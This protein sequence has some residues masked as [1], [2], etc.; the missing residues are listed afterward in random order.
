MKKKYLIRLTSALFTQVLSSCY[1]QK[2]D[3]TPATP[4]TPSENTV[5]EEKKTDE[6]LKHYTITWKHYDGRV[7]AKTSISEGKLPIYPKQNPRRAE[8][9]TSKYEF[10]GW[11][12]EIAVAKSDATYTAKFNEIKKEVVMGDGFIASDGSTKYSFAELIE[13]GNQYINIDETDNE[14]VIN[15][16]KLDAFSKYGK[17]II[18]E[19]YKE[20]NITELYM[21]A[22]Y[23]LN[24]SE[25]VE[26]LYLPSTLKK[27]GLQSVSQTNITSLTLPASLQNCGPRAFYKSSKLKTVKILCQNCNFFIEEEQGDGMNHTFYECGAL[28]EVNFP[29]AMN[30]IYPMFY[31]CSALKKVYLPEV[32]KNIQ[33]EAFFASSSLSNIDFPEGLENIEEWAFHGCGLTSVT[34]PKSLKYCSNAFD[35]CTKLKYAIIKAG[36]EKLKISNSAFSGCPIE[37]IYYEGSESD[38]KTKVEIEDGK[39]APYISSSKESESIK[40]YY[41]SETKKDNCWH[42]GD[43]NVPEKW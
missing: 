7:L 17:L 9:E 21:G 36:T 15:K 22:I 42:Y 33:S 30:T 34:L 12:P 25:F 38:F 32:V 20:K 6:E 31:K 26:E 11:E 18:P 3:D 39:K 10:A 41:Y 40:I 37:A 43:N 23:P 5:V 28:E 8:T 13:N 27:I 14:I 35:D 1:V 2:K 16:V 4:S 29:L 24:G 19:T